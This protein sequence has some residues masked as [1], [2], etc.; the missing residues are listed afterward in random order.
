MNRRVLLWAGC[1]LWL[2]GQLGPASA[3]CM[4]WVFRTDVSGPGP[5]TRHCMPYNPDRQRVV[6]FTSDT[7][8]DLWEYD[9]V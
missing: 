3:Q 4:K 8:A 9:G 7:A 6:L 5:Q 1:L 2:A